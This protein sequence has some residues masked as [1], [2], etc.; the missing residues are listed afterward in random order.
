MLCTKLQFRRENVLVYIYI[1]GYMC[2]TYFWTHEDCI[3]CISLLQR[4]YSIWKATLYGV[5]LSQGH[6]HEKNDFEGLG[7]PGEQFMSFIIQCEYDDDD[8][9]DNDDDDDD[10]DDNNNNNGRN[11]SY[12]IRLATWNE[13]DI[14]GL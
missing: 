4:K 2:R 7:V 12:F 10:D 5:H 14:C 9:D 11:G 13:W 8:D 6:T 3:Y 1:S